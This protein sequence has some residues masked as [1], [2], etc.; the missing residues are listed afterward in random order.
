MKVKSISVT[1]DK[2]SKMQIVSVAN[3]TM[4]NGEIRTA[5]EEHTMQILVMLGEDKNKSI[6]L[7]PT[8]FR[9]TL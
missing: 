2:K 3:D 6:K 4:F 9:F 5:N 8:I 7:A 1:K